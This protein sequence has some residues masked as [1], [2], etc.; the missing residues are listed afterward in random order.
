MLFIGSNDGKKRQISD[1]ENSDIHQLQPLPLL[2]VVKNIWLDYNMLDIN[3]NQWIPKDSVL[4]F[5]LK[6]D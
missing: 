1:E 3:W 4:I 6:N 2:A 5:T